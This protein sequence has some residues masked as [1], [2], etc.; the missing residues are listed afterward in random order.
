MRKIEKKYE[1]TDVFSKK[2]ILTLIIG[3]AYPLV[4][5]MIFIQLRL[6]GIYL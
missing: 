1:N 2:N 6:R 3:Y 5:Y 4:I